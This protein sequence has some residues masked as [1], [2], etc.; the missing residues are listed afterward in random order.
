LETHLPTEL[1]LIERRKS[2]R[3][4]S[5]LTVEAKEVESKD[6]ETLFFEHA[7]KDLSSIEPGRSK[8]VKDAIT[9]FTQN[10]S[11]GGLMLAA[12]MPFH[13]GAA[14]ALAV[15][16]PEVPMPVHA[17]ALVVWTDKEADGRFTCGLR[18]IA[19]SQEDTQRVD[20]YVLLQKRAEINKKMG[21]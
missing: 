2:E 14:L 13:E 4:A 7:Y 20:R 8:P 3:M 19:I 10:I 9:V 6:V 1:E 5:N 16:I 17:L 21:Q 12:E 18:F 15:H 11:V